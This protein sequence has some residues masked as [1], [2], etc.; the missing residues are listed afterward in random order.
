MRVILLAG[1]KGAGKTVLAEALS[2]ATSLPR[3]SFGDAVRA[4]ARSKGMATDTSTLQDLGQSIVEKNPS[5]LCEQVLAQA[6]T[7]GTGLVIDGLRHR[8]VFAA[9]KALCAPRRTF[10]V[11]IDIDPAE[12]VRRIASRDGADESAVHRMNLHEVEGQLP[13]IRKVADLVVDGALPAIVNVDLVLQALA[14]ASLL[15]WR[16]R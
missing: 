7:D 13:E 14:K 11:F 2:A 12:Q 10:L 16:S 15:S 1:A 5:L 8:E 6:A 3:V 4:I 9:L